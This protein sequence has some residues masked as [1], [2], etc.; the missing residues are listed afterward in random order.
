MQAG[1]WFVLILAVILVIAWASASAEEERRR[2]EEA[3]RSRVKADEWRRRAKQIAAES[4][5]RQRQE[6][7]A[8]LRSAIADDLA[9]E[10]R[11]RADGTYV[12]DPATAEIAM[13]RAMVR[14]LGF[15][16]A[17]C[18]GRGADE[19][20]DIM[21]KGAL[22]QV[23]F[24]QAKV[25]RPD[26][27][28][29]VGAKQNNRVYANVLLIFFAFGDAP[30]SKPAIDYADRAAVALFSYNASGAIFPVNGAAAAMRLHD[31]EAAAKANAAWKAREALAAE[32]SRKTRTG[33]PCPCG[34]T[35]VVRRRRS[36][37]KRF[38][39]CSR[40]PECVETRNA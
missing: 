1:G 32:R 13:E 15:A 35:F 27:Q 3:E 26:V 31:S 33:D 22:A 36:D 7:Q 14:F 24:Q 17:R 16:D 11:A 19:G 10:K 2:H 28:R 8:R 6:D 39:G 5:Q 12:K 21:A 23:K 29:L 20:V 18:T 34:G 37:N 4:R 9:A 38:L 30:Y 40:Y 25:S